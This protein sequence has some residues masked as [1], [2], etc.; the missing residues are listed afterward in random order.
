MPIYIHHQIHSVGKLMSHQKTV[1][2]LNSENCVPLVTSFLV[3]VGN[4]DEKMGFG[5]NVYRY[6]M[7]AWIPVTF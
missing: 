7:K 1:N 6:L 5:D 2:T 4:W 3:I